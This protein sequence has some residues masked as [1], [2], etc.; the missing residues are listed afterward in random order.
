MKKTW[1]TPELEELVMT[2]TANGLDKSN[3]FDGDWVNI[4][5]L[6]YRPGDGTVSPTK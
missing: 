4:N 1:N 5:G 3:D 2:A 6:W